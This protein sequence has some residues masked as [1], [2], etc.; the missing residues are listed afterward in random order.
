MDPARAWLNDI[1]L[2]NES[3]AEDEPGDVS[4]F[5]SAEEAL[6]WIEDW[7][8]EDGEGF[9]FS[10]AGERLVLGVG[11]NGVEIVRREPCAQGEAIV[12]RWLRARAEHMLGRRRALAEDRTCRLAPFEERGALPGTVE[13]LL[14]YQAMAAATLPRH[15]DSPFSRSRSGPPSPASSCCFS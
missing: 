1:V 4:L 13:G 11:T 14:A 6:R 15:R 12:L 8:V 2:V 10:A 9:A 7:W 5:L 3:R